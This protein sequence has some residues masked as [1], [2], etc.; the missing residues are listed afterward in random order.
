MA[1]SSKRKSMK[2]AQKKRR[3][4]MAAY[5]AGGGESRYARKR[6]YCVKNNVWGFEVPF[7]KPWGTSK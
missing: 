5:L 1:K 4:D 2:E 7:P 3:K 6:K